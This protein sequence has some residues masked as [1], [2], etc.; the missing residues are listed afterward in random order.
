MLELLLQR[1]ISIEKEREQMS[2]KGSKNQLTFPSIF[3]T[4][5]GISSTACLTALHGHCVGGKCSGSKGS[6]ACSFC[7]AAKVIVIG[8]RWH[9]LKSRGSRCTGAY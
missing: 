3:N 4:K 7:V 6:D 1:H 8:D 9:N 2:L 5:V